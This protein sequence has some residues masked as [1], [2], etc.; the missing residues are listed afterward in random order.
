MNNNKLDIKV[1]NKKIF[2]GYRQIFMLPREI[3]SLSLSMYKRKTHFVL[4]CVSVYFIS[5]VVVFHAR[6]ISQNPANQIMTHTMGVV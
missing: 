2:Y 3:F 6:Y 5:L 4:F 1:R